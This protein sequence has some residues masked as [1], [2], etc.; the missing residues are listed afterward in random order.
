MPTLDR[1]GVAIHYEDHGPRDAD[2]LPVLLTHGYAATCLMWR[3]QIAA[4]ADRPVS[5]LYSIP[6]QPPVLWDLPQ[7][8][9]F[10]ARCPVAE[11]RC[12][13]RYPPAFKVADSAAGDHVASCWKLE[14]PA[15]NTPKS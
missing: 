9:R 14:D 15:W 12:E 4:F 1:D 3:P 7:G 2:T 11:P 6:G 5:R 13:T 8:C 10:V